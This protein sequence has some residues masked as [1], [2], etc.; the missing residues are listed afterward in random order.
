GPHHFAD[1]ASSYWEEI[2]LRVY[3][4]YQDVLAQSHAL[5]FDDL[6]MS[7]MRLFREQPEVLARY[8]ERYVHILV[9]EF[10]DTNVAQYQIVK[11]IAG[12][13]RNLC[14]V[15]DEDQSIYSWRGANFRNVL[16]FET[17]FPDAKVIL[18]QQ[19]YRSTKT[20]LDAAR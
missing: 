11:Q 3:K 17:D 9:D 19:N 8:Q 14:V 13:H 18:L 7:T 16:N 1:D 20:I 12:K 5:D 6:L 15:G 10:Q 2:V 4:R